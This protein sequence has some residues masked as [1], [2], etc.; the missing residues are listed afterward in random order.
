MPDMN[1]FATQAMFMDYQQWTQEADKKI[2]RDREEWRRIQDEE[3]AE[4]ARKKKLFLE[5]TPE[6]WYYAPADVHVPVRFTSIC[7][8]DNANRSFVW[9]NDDG[10]YSVATKSMASNKKPFTVDEYHQ[11]FCDY[12]EK[13][14]IWIYNAK[15]DNTY[16]NP[17]EDADSDSND[18]NEII[19]DGYEDK[20]IDGYTSPGGTEYE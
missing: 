7:D 3:A 15:N 14:K 17:F 16:P 13:R 19:D 9:I 4:R 12:D 20:Y 1:N 2:E 10:S 11:R 6:F 18:E 8:I 5:K